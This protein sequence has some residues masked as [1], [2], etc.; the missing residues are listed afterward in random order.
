M[1]T[2]FS[3]RTA[4]KSALGYSLLIFV[5][6]I[7]YVAAVYP[8]VERNPSLPQ[9]VLLNELIRFGIF[10]APVLLYLK[11]IA[12]QEPFRYLK[13]NTNVSCGVL[14]GV[15]VG[16]IYAALVLAWASLFLP[17]GVV[18][19]PVPL[20]AWLTSLTVST[21]IEEIAFRGFL[22]QQ[23]ERVV[24]FWMANLLTACLFVA[25]HFPGWFLS[26]GATLVSGKLIAMAEIL[27]LGLLLG[28]LF[29]RTGSLWSCFILHA[30]NNSAAI[31]L[32][33]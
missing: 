11:F 28:H 21:L 30:A 16:I 9:R 27:L 13:L 3:N 20:E 22:L 29:K 12:C 4:L 25:I 19:K 6:W 31:I 33:G 5:L 18:F 8:S 10:V 17:S 26:S 24:N 7:V 2:D 23:L 1:L 14:W 15:I 32:F